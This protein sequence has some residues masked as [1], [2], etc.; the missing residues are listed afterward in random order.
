M[1]TA[2][3]FL[4]GYSRLSTDHDGCL[5]NLDRYYLSNNLANS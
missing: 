3:I 4:P 2:T 5:L 1:V